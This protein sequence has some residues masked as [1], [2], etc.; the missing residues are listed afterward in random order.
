MLVKELRY[1]LH[2]IFR[3]IDGFWD[4][5]HEKRGSFKAA[6]II[7]A[8][9]LI[10]FVII[11][12]YTGFLFNPVNLLYVNIFREIVTFLTIFVLFVVSN[13]CLTTLM[14]GKGTMADIAMATAYALTPFIL[15]NLPLVAFSNVITL[16]ESAFY[17]MFLTIGVLWTAGLI[18]LGT[19]VTHEYTMSKT[20]LTLFFI[21]VGMMIMVFLGLLFFS[22]IQRIVG[23]I[24][25][26]YKEITFRM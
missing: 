16:Q 14:D 18:I 12:R 22:V 15:I 17:Y 8:A 6:M 20:L 10:T 7:L 19:M 3:P 9:A 24:Y 26:L 13:W 1:S 11:E 23:L 5:K 4:L 2:V 21:I 25:V